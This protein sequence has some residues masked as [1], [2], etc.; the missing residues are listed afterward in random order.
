MGRPAQAV[1]SSVMGIQRELLLAIAFITGCLCGFGSAWLYRVSTN[2]H[3]D[4]RTTTASSSTT[5]AISETPERPLSFSR[6]GLDEL[7]TARRDEVFSISGK[8]V[9]HASADELLALAEAWQFKVNRS[10]SPQNAWMLLLG[11]LVAFD[12]ETA[13]ELGQQLKANGHHDDFAGFILRT[14]FA[15]DPMPALAHAKT[16]PHR[17]LP[18]IVKEV[19]RRDMTLALKLLDG[20]PS[21]SKMARTVLPELAKT[22]PLGAVGRAEAITDVRARDRTLRTLVFSWAKRDPDAALAYIANLDR[23]TLQL[24]HAAMEALIKEDPYKAEVVLQTLLPPG[25]TRLRIFRALAQRKV[26]DDPDAALA[27]AR[28]LPDSPERMTAIGLAAEAIT[29]GVPERVLALLDEIGWENAGRNPA[30]TTVSFTMSGGGGGSWDNGGMSDLAKSALLELAKTDPANAMGKALK[31]PPASDNF[32]ASERTNLLVEMARAWS[33][34]DIVSYVD[35]LDQAGADVIPSELRPSLNQMPLDQANDLESRIPS[36]ESSE[37]KLTLERQ[38][39]RRLAESEPVRAFEMA[40]GLV[41]ENRAK[42]LFRWLKA[43]PKEMR[44]RD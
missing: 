38:L 27:W 18:L 31:L 19:A 7:L 34:A 37:L 26:D 40:S 32:M 25:K 9:T 39:A 8:F 23:P 10:N 2:E 22:D 21:I 3:S 14:W 16:D 28:G 33:T 35:W 41:G 13:L 29:E 17:L 24:K 6:P 15:L 5:I 44:N 4:D 1:A 43:W 11:R 12:P 30:T 36:L 20:H 42:R